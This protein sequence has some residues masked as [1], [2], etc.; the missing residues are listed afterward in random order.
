MDGK[1]WSSVRCNCT[2]IK[3]KYKEE[4][5][6]KGASFVMGINRRVAEIEGGGRSFARVKRFALFGVGM[7]SLM[8]NGNVNNVF[9]WK[10]FFRNGSIGFSTLQFE[11]Y[12]V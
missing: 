11:N 1:G 2:T 10:L 12:M 7:R 6:F 8:V 4:A 5:P 9:V 3:T